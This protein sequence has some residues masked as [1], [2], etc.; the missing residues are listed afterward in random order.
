MGIYF[1]GVSTTSNRHFILKNCMDYR[2]IEEPEIN[3]TV[4]LFLR[5]I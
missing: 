5:P 1:N 3:T 2:V 4:V